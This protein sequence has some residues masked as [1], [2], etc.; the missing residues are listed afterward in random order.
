MAQL[1]VERAANLKRK[2]DEGLG[3]MPLELSVIKPNPGPQTQFWESTCREIL[4]GG[5]AGGG[6]SWALACFPL[7]FAHL[8]GLLVLTLRRDSTQFEDLKAKTYEWYPK[9]LPGLQP[10]K[11]PHFRYNFPSG[12]TNIFG[13]CNNDEDYLQYQG[14]EINIVEFDELTHFTRQQYNEICSRVRTVKPG[15]PTLIRASTNP[16]G[17]G[18]GWVFKH[19]GAWL[20]PD[21]EAEGLPAKAD[22][23]KGPPCATGSV[24]WI[25]TN[26]DGS[27][28]YF[29]E[30]PAEEAGIAPAL[31]RTFIASSFKDTPQLTENDPAYVAQLNM[32]DPVRRSQLRDGNWLVKPGAGL[33]FRRAWCN[34]VEIDDV[35]TKAL[36][37]RYWDRAAT[38]ETD[39]SPNPDATSG[40]L[41][42]KSFEP[43]HYWIIDETRARLSPNK[44]DALIDETAKIDVEDW[45]PEVLTAFSQDPG[46]AGKDQAQKNVQRL[47][48]YRVRSR[49]E[50]GPKL[51]RFYPFSSQAEPQAGARFGNVSIVRGPWNEAYLSQLDAFDGDKNNG[52]KDDAAD[53]TSGAFSEIERMIPVLN[54]P[55]DQMKTH[56]Y[57][58]QL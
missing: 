58:S 55:R 25:R 18:H 22:R 53:A 35:P 7:K 4:Y 34:I 17:E 31:S 14:W 41:M 37:C 1:L 50:T 5:S 12:A 51:T 46:Q 57:E 43:V 20:D 23:P 11:S 21:F 56:R 39:A 38:E 19:W 32:L 6:K 10:I 3:P 29:S 48:G 40:V 8:P 30:E 36:F 54:V 45:G 44:V 26:G 13:H 49:R 47:A 16:G 52:E 2:K 9:V 24:W 42:A 33:Y 15:Y 28:T 27:E